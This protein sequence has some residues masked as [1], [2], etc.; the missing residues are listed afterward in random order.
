M[1][2]VTYL[3]LLKHVF[4]RISDFELIA[5]N[6]FSVSSYIGYKFILSNALYDA[7]FSDTFSNSG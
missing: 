1:M 2:E 3:I 7:A 4:R 5:H 6:Y